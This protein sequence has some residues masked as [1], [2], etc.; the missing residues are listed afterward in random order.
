MFVRFARG[1][2]QFYRRPL[3]PGDCCGPI[4]EQVRRREASFLTMLER[5]VYGHEPSPYRRLLAWAGVELGDLRKLVESDGVEAA[6]AKLRQ[7]GVYVTIEEFKGRRSIRRSGLEIPVSAE[8]FNSPLLTRHFDAQ[9][10]GSGGVARSLI[11]DFDQISDDAL[12][13]GMFLEMFGLAE[14]PS[15]IWRPALPGAAGPR[16]AFILTRLGSPL[17][18]WFSQQRNRLRPAE[19]KPLVMNRFLALGSRLCGRP[20]PQPEWTPLEDAPRVARWAAACVGRGAPPLIDTMVSGGVRVCLAARDLGLDLS[21]TFFRFGSEPYTAAKAQVIAG[22]GCRATQFYATTESG[23]VG[24]G[25][26]APNAPDDVH[27]MLGKIAV[28]EDVRPPDAPEGLC[29]YL[30]TLIPNAPKLMLNVESGDHGVLEE[31][32][33]DCDFERCG[34]R[35]HIR[36][37]QS[38]EKLTAGGMLFLADD[39]VRLVEQVLPARFGGGPT[40]YQI[41]EDIRPVLPQ[42]QIVV[43]PRVGAVDEA[44]VAAAA[45][46]SLS[47]KSTADGMMAAVWKQGSI[48]QVVRREPH[49]TGAAKVPALHVIRAEEPAKEPV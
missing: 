30:T 40:D 48:L 29:F 21:G 32:R 5:A 33:C 23:H 1:M 27:V 8:D 22:A 13:Y 2:R 20:I 16:K 44:A 36:N 35:L 41:V 4:G 14:R 28:L 43:S 19:L 31:R 49:V 34:Q 12:S 42:V 7:A 17:E 11:L 37:L 25:C 10:G 15:A 45:L 38:Y 9:T 46:E 47:S 24:V 3:A 6:L 39:V 26:G 18:R